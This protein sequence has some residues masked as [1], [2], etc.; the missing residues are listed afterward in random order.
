[1]TEIQLRRLARMELPR[2]VSVADCTA[3][4]ARAWGITA[5]IHSSPDYEAI[6]AELIQTVADRFGIRVVR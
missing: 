2:T 1:M 4:N 3:E 6:G 5:E